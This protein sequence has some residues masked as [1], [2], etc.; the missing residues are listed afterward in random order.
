MGEKL[1][2]KVQQFFQTSANINYHYHTDRLIPLEH[3]EADIRVLTLASTTFTPAVAKHRV[4]QAVFY[5]MIHTRV[6]PPE[7][8]I[9]FEPLFRDWRPGPPII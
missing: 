7:S 1:L 6:R 5:L 8:S 3:N 2:K 9:I 4:E